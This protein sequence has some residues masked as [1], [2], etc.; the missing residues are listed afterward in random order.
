[1]TE[2]TAIKFTRHQGQAITV[3]E[4]P[5]HARIDLRV[6]ADR[7]A[8]LHMPTPDTIVFADQVVYRITGYTDG[9]LELE[10]VEDWR[11]TPGEPKCAICSTLVSQHEGRI[12]ERPAPV[13]EEKPLTETDAKALKTKWRQEHGDSNIVTT[14]TPK[15]P[16]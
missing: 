15:E 3:D 4:A 16:S 13:V 9:Q 11:P 8:Y 1:V 12:C 6:I 10:L 2:P 5:P 14:V 7:Y